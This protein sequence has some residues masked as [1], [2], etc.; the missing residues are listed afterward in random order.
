MSVYV[1]PIGRP[2]VHVC[3]ALTIGR[4]NEFGDEHVVFARGA[5]TP[6]TVYISWH[7]AVLQS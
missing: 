4:Q 7:L 1:A 2:G 6:P 5:I 3:V